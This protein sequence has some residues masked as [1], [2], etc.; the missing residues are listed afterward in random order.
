[1]LVT[2]RVTGTR[3]LVSG[4]TG[5][6]ETGGQLVQV[7]LG[8]DRLR[9]LD[10]LA[11]STNA[12]SASRPGRSRPRASARTAVSV[13]SLGADQAEPGSWTGVEAGRQ[14]AGGGRSPE[15][16][17]QRPRH[18]VGGGLQRA[19]AGQPVVAGRGRL[20]SRST[21]RPAGR[22]G[23]PESP[24]PWP[25]P[26][27]GTGV[28]GRALSATCR[29]TPSRPRRRGSITVGDLRQGCVDTGLRARPA[30]R[31]AV[32]AADR[33][34][35]AY[36][37][38]GAP[39]RRRWPRRR[40]GRRAGP[41]LVPHALVDG[42][43]ATRPRLRGRSRSPPGGLSVGPVKSELFVRRARA[44]PLLLAQHC[45]VCRARSHP[46]ARGRGSPR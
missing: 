29:W 25:A 46:T 32:A 3:P 34:G 16:R 18:R 1:M 14:G 36:A 5:G 10:S 23:R 19:R 35:D 30:S 7:L 8:L 37:W 20:P 42:G 27:E 2:L 13:R 28:L 40:R 24:S 12:A 9:V 41:S 38:L 15:P 22:R 45:A 4:C 11:E 21:T 26:A 44:P 17:E 31:A 6:A 43:P 39:P 33:P